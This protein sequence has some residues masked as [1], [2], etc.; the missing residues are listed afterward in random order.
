L[1]GDDV[2]VGETII[3]SLYLIKKASSLENKFVSVDKCGDDECVN[4]GTEVD[5]DGG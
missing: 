5:L 4:A 3:F 2:F 1:E